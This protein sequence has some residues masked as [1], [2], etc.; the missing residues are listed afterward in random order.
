M[1]LLQ[2]LTKPDGTKGSKIELVETKQSIKKVVELLDSRVFGQYHQQPYI[3]HHFKMLL[4]GKMRKDVHANLLVNDAACYTDYSKE[5]EI[6][7][8]EQVKSAAFGAS[9]LTIQLI[10][11]G[12]SFW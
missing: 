1:Q 5:I 7:P 11:Q 6:V 4:G 3:L 8:Q 12:P 10:G 2:Y 9:N